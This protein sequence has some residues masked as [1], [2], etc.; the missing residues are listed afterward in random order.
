MR[1]TL[2]ARRT[3]DECLLEGVGPGADLGGP[4]LQG[5]APL[6]DRGH[7]RRR[8]LAECRVVV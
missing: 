8:G 5:H 6:G 2:E 7:G 4:C 1:L 3:H